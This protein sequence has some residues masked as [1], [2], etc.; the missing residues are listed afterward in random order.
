MEE[1]E[2]TVSIQQM[3]QAVMEVG[4]AE[5]GADHRANRQGAKAPRALLGSSGEQVEPFQVMQ[6]NRHNIKDK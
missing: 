2:L 1:L 3:V 4:P 5:A 6:L